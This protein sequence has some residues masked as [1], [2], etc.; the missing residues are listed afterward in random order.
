M[1]NP[2]KEPFTHLIALYSYYHPKHFDAM[3]DAYMK[4]LSRYDLGAWVCECGSIVPCTRKYWVTERCPEC[5]GAK[6]SNAPAYRKRH[7]N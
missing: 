1:K 4:G 6:D 7:K 3:I 5:N 2:E